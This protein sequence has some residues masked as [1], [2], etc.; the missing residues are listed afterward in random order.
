MGW[1]AWTRL[2]MSVEEMAR[3]GTSRA[4]TFGWLVGASFSNLAMS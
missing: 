2:L 4:D 3:A 1:P